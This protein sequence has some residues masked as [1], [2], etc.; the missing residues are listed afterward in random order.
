MTDN[1]GPVCT[2]D[3]NSITVKVEHP[4]YGPM[5]RS[6]TAAQLSSLRMFGEVEP[7][8]SYPP[9]K[10]DVYEK[11]IGEESVIDFIENS[12][13]KFLV[14]YQRNKYS[15]PGK[16]TKGAERQRVYRQNESITQRER[17]LEMARNYIR[18]RR[19]NESDQ[20]RVDRLRK[21]RERIRAIRQAR[22]MDPEL[23]KMRRQAEAD[24]M[25]VR[26]ANE[27][28]LQR[29]MRLEKSRMYSRR[30]RENEMYRSLE[31]ERNRMAHQY[32]RADISFRVQE[33]QRDRLRKKLKRQNML[34]TPVE[35]VIV[36][37]PPDTVVL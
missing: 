24:R 22:K 36:Y 9:Y 31:N 8:N 26:R 3:L 11:I 20:E 15:A 30:K 37:P 14:S 7:I 16:I 2:S 4:E 35:T 6:T 25:K 1:C 5:E 34:E 23:D 33:R 19:E 17:R 29:M 13:D 18:K 28:P 21:Q 27:T 10:P 12:I 32:K